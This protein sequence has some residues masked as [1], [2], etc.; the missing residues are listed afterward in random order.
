MQGGEEK[1]RVIFGHLDEALR[2]HGCQRT[3]VLATRVYVTDMVRM[4]PLVNRAYED[5]FGSERPTRTIV[6]V[7]ALNQD[8]TVEIEVVIADRSDEAS[9]AT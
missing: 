2:A 1:L 5:Y 4:R 7:G 3:D 6:E 9:A 8:D